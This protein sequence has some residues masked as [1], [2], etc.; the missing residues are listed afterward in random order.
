MKLYSQ[1]DQKVGG[2]PGYRIKRQIRRLYYN[3]TYDQIRKGPRA[4][5]S[6]R[7]A[8]SN[9]LNAQD[10]GANILNY[11]SQGMAER[12]ISITRREKTELKND[13]GSRKTS[14][15]GAKIAPVRRRSSIFLGEK[16]LGGGSF[17]EM[18]SPSNQANFQEII[19]KKGVRPM[20]I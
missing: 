3:P 2:S 19:K 15:S 14:I 10:T 8:G 11:S 5:S 20:H 17:L 12:E 9:T 13:T 18:V 16:N 6:S 7:K 1:E 4:I